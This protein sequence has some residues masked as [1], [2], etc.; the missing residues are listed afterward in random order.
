VINNDVV[1][2]TGLVDVPPDVCEGHVHAIASRRLVSVVLLLWRKLRTMTSFL[3]QQ[4]AM[5]DIQVPI[6]FI[7]T[8]TDMIEVEQ[9]WP[10][11]GCCM[12]GNH[13]MKLG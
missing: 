11:L 6:V 5:G 13:P 8:K 2:R 1:V 7:A 10:R 9:V 12:G 4:N 3:R